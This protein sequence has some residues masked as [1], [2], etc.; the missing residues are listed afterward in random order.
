MGDPTFD[1]FYRSIVPGLTSSVEI[2]EL[3][4]AAG[5]ELLDKIG[6]GDSLIEQFS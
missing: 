5:Q 1:S 2:S 4:K 3:M 6:V